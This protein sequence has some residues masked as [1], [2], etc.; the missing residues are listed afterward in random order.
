MNIV[1]IAQSADVPRTVQPVERPIISAFALRVHDAE[2]AFRRA[3][4]LGAWA[5]PPRA[6]AMELNIPA[7]HGVGESLVYFVDRYRDF[8]IYDIDFVPLAA[9]AARPAALAGLHWFG[10]V[11]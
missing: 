7:I 9:T 11:Q 4:D 6:R 3:L 2:T 5:I 8:S 1:V 10:V